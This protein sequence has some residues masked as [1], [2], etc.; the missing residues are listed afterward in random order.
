MPTATPEQVE[1]AVIECL[2]IGAPAAVISWRPIIPFTKAFPSKTSS[3]LS[4]RANNTGVIANAASFVPARKNKTFLRQVYEMKPG[5]PV[6]L[7]VQPFGKW[8]ATQEVMQDWALDLARQTQRNREQ[9]Q[10][11]DFSGAA[12]Q[13]WHW[14]GRNSRVVRAQCVWNDQSDA[15]IRPLIG[16]ILKQ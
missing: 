12:S 10:V 5:L 9:E 3:P 13:D 16:P 1:R 6:P 4:R 15:W 11:Y 8:Y 2:S 7:L 14:P